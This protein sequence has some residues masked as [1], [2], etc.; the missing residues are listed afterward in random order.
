MLCAAIK[1]L[2]SI[3]KPPG[4]FNKWCL[5]VSWWLFAVAVTQWWPT[6]LVGLKLHIAVCAI[7]ELYSIRS[8]SFSMACCNNRLMTL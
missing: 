7:S 2:A 5:Q 1:G 6:E 8:H 4:K 3:S